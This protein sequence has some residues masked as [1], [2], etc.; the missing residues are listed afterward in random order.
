MTTNRT[1]LALIAR[2]IDTGT[3]RRLRTKHLTL[4]KLQQLNPDEFNLLGLTDV[5]IDSIR[6]SVRPA[7]PNRQLIR[8]LF[9]NRFLCCVCREPKPVVVHHIK[10]WAKTHDHSEKNLAVLCTHHH[11]EAHIRRDLETTLNPE[12][13]SQLKAQWEQEVERLDGNSICIATQPKSDYWYYFN[14][15][16]LFE[17]AEQEGVNLPRVE[18]FSH[19]RRLGLCDKNGHIVKPNAER[20]MYESQLSMPLYSFV[21]NVFYECLAILTVRNISDLL[22]PGTVLP[23]IVENDVIYVQGAHKFADSPLAKN[24][25]QLAAGTRSANHVEIAY[26]FDRF[27]STSN[28][29]WSLWLRGTQSVG[30]LIHV[31]SVQRAGQKVCILGTVL[32]IGLP[33]M[34]LKTRVYEANLYKSVLRRNRRNVQI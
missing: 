29:A 10:P 13:L 21:K 8:V 15:L 4:A 25:H 7:I 20:F 30:S 6:K 19:A 33:A 5:Q 34:E 9:R 31:K 12:K 2:G 22:D 17:M 26:V 23:L 11:G 3:A 27:E 24:G 1:E 14:H 18:G 16:R 32:A 28:S